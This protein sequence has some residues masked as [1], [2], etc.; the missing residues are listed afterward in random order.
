MGNRIITSEIRSL[1]KCGAVGARREVVMTIEPCPLCAWETDDRGV[2]W[3][4]CAG[5]CANKGVSREDARVIAKSMETTNDLVRQYNAKSFSPGMQP[6]SA[7][8][9]IYERDLRRA[10]DQGYQESPRKWGFVDTSQPVLDAIRWLSSRCDGAHSE[11]RAG[12]AK[13]DVEF[14]HWLASIDS[15]GSAKLGDRALKLVRKYRKQ[16]EKGGFD[17]SLLLDSESESAA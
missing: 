3:P 12:F 4:I 13:C 2:R 17:V 16:L 1:P 8:E 15:I 5:R 6:G 7:S 14:G 9:K 10:V 11:D